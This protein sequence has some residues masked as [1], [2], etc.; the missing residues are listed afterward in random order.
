MK[1]LFRGIR[2]SLLACGLIVVALATAVSAESRLQSF[3]DDRYYIGRG[4]DAP[5]LSALA[6]NPQ[7]YF[8]SESALQL[9]ASH[10]GVSEDSLGQTLQELTVEDCRGRGIVTA[11]LSSSGELVRMER[12]CYQGEQLLMRSVNGRQMVVMSLGCLNPVYR[13]IEN[14]ARTMVA[15]PPSTAVHSPQCRFVRESA[16]QF[17]GTTQRLNDFSHCNCFSVPG[18]TI[19]TPATIQYTS[20][21]VCD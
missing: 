15:S 4:G 12:A 17:S 14:E 7:T 5:S 11:G 21:F 19:Q 3:A 8:R 6:A 20:R 2:H 16:Q 13:I 1:T 10:L 9:L 18:A